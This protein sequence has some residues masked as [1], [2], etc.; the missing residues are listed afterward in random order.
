MK[1][2][3]W[4]CILFLLCAVVLSFLF[5]CDYGP[6]GTGATTV[7]RGTGILSESLR[8]IDD[9][10]SGYIPYDAG[11]FSFA[12]D[13]TVAEGARYTVCADLFCMDI[14]PEKVIPIH[15][16]DNMWYLL[17]E[18]GSERTM[19]TVLIR[20]GKPAEITF[21]S[22][23]GSACEPMTVTKELPIGVLPVPTL[24][25]YMFDGWFYDPLCTER[26]SETDDLTAR[27]G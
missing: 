6:S 2:R 13:I 24:W 23:E 4:L 22:G 10:A 15:D 7:P 3:H 21:D 16:G 20:R 11:T 19:Y 17:V 27:A 18:N 26:V 9:R 8:V 12:D 1:I 5:S 25:G 14:V